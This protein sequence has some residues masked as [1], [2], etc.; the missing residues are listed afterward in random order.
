MK[1][2][3][4]EFVEQIPNGSLKREE[5]ILKFEVLSSVNLF[6]KTNLSIPKNRIYLTVGILSASVGS[7]SGSSSVKVIKF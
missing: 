5:R 1:G 6:N 4:V 2:L 7:F 3:A